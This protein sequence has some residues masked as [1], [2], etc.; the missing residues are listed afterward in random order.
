MIKII[1]F[2]TE[3][4]NTF[5]DVEKW[6]NH[7]F[8]PT[9]LHKLAFQGHEKLANQVELYTYQ[10]LDV[11]FKSIIIKDAHDILDYRKAFDALQKGHSIAHISDAIRIKRASE[12]NGIVL[13]SDAVPIKKFPEHETWY[14]TMPCKKT[15]GFAPKWGESKPPMKVHDGSWDGK[16]LTAFPI[17]IGNST[18]EQ[19]NQLAENIFKLLKTNPKETSNEWNSVLWT[20]KEI[21][22]RDVNGVVFKPIYMCP[23]PAWLS[24]NKCY[25][26][27]SPTRLNGKTELFGH[28]LPSVNE[29]MS[30]SYIIQHFFESAFQKGTEKKSWTLNDLPLDCL[31][32]KEYLHIHG[33][34]MENKLNIFYL[35]K[36]DIKPFK[37]NP[38]L[39]SKEQIKQIANSIK[40]FGFRIPIAIDETNTILAGHG[41]FKA[42]E[43]LGFTEMPCIQHKDLTP[44]QKKAFVIADNK[45]TLNST[46]DMETLWNQVQ[47]LNGLGFDLDVLGFDN[48]ELLPMLDSNTVSDTLGEWENMPDFNQDDATPDSTIYVHFTNDKDRQDFAKLLGQN[49]TEKTKTLWFP[50][51][52]QMDTKNKVYE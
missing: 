32:R 44:L 28:K 19:F 15:G 35:K 30:K 18:K 4:N 48:A 37:D 41:R 22:N 36:E 26:I 34:K 43:S 39:H 45:I 8:I 42:A 3:Y 17:K 2:W 38:R 50:P 12:V 25:S 27:E 11:N 7:T 24:A 40:E 47:E 49:I 31:L 14:S 21:A 6:R 13:D 20:V 5:T 9:E 46:W 52:E 10:R 51:Q 16:E 23:L 33:E 29:I 1:L